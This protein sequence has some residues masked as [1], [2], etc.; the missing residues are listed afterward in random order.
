MQ[1]GWLVVEAGGKTERIRLEGEQAIG[2]AADNQVVIAE[3]F[4]SRHHA[5]LIWND[6]VPTLLDQGSSCGLTVLGARVPSVVLS[7]SIVVEIRGPEPGQLV[8]LR[9]EP[10]APHSEDPRPPT[11]ALADSHAL[12]GPPTSMLVLPRTDTAITIGR[13]ETSGIVLDHPSVSRLH[14]TFELRGGTATLTDSS[15]NGTFVNGERIAGRRVLKVGDRI[16]I[17]SFELIFDGARLVQFDQVGRAR[18][19]AV[20]LTRVVGDGVTILHDVSLSALPREM[21]A[22]VGTS[23]AGKSTLM[24]ALNGF[25]PAT[26]G[27]VLLNGRDYYREFAALRLLVGYVPQSDVVHRDLTTERA[28]TYAARLRLTGDHSADEAAGRV[29]AVLD[30]VGLADRRAVPVNQLSG[31]QIKR[32]SIGVELLT[33]PSLFFLD[34]PTSGLDPGYEKHVMELL[35]ALADQDKTIVLITHATQNI[36]LCDH[37]A[38]MAPG[39]YLA[40]FGPPKAALEYFEVTDYPGI[41]ARLQQGPDASGLAERFQRHEAYRRYVEGR[42]P[43]AAIDAGSGGGAQP[44]PAAAPVPAHRQFAT[45]VERYTELIVRDRRNL[46]LLLLQAPIIGLLI[47][48]VS[49][50]QAFVSLPDANGARSVLVMLACSIIWL[51]TM[52]A[53]REIVKEQPIYRRERMVGL[54][55]VPYLASKYV[56]LGALA[57]AQAAVLLVPVL[58]RSQ[59]PVGGVFLP[60]PLEMYATLALCAVA[61]VAMGLMLSTLFGNA[62]RAAA[63]VPYVLIPQILF[64]VSK[65][66]GLGQWISWLTTSHWAVQALGASADLGRFSTALTGIDPDEFARNPNF[67]LAR[68]L[69]IAIVGVGCAVASLI[70]LK[71]HDGNLL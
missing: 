5:K 16:R 70:L 69:I 61:A 66:E 45:L 43:A 59:V 6:G 11:P 2:R 64:V 8:R 3:P 67:L 47:A 1:A 34:E 27:T 21:V 7:P 38:F 42:L 40:Y 29:A 50:P 52:N 33:R 60:A 22:I 65:L 4:V 26:T 15:T 31:G 9:F 37:V 57:L 19:D 41:Y 35:R 20:H 14:A 71:R 13:A 56:V 62:D 28:L 23:G 32:V 44:L 10:E 18:L 24:D 17:A 39:G 36:E 55:L 49:K 53:A 46:L 58:V 63:L 30:E 68:W 25:R 51:G 54:G 12:T 48:I